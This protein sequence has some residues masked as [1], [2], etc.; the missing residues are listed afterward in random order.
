MLWT[1]VAPK[2]GEDS[3]ELKLEVS[4]SKD[5]ADVIAMDTLTAEKDADHTVRVLVEGLSSN[6]T[7]NVARRDQAFFGV[8]D[9][10]QPFAFT[11]LPGNSWH[12]PRP[13]GPPL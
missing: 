1:R 11:D 7:R 9:T 6:R 4:E 8:C 2:S 3:I 10:H 5:F 12:G 13:V